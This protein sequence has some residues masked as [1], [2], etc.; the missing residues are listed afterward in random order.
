SGGGVLPDTGRL[1]VSGKRIGV[2]AIA[3]A[4]VV[5]GLLPTLPPDPLFGFGV[6][7]GPGAG[8]GTIG[9]PD[10][11]VKLGGQLRRPENTPVLTYTTSDGRPRYLRIYSLDRFDGTTWRVGTLQ[12]RREDRVSAGPLP[13]PPGL[14]PGIATRRAETQI[15]ISEDI[16]RLNFLPL[17]YPPTQ[18]DVDGDWRADRRS[19]LV[20][21]TEDEAAGLSYR[22]VTD[23]PEPTTE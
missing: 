1:A 14:G 4:I 11:M 23:D 21:S 3:L 18:V 22:V 19:L 20:F 10:A 15:S 17:P 8:G 5:P 12:G 6:G 13:P 7:G 2:M 9:V 16:S